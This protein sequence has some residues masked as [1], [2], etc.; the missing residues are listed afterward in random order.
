MAETRDLLIEIGTEELPP[1]ALRK[2]SE[3]LLQELSH[4]LQAAGLIY[5][6][7]KGYGAPRRLAV[8]VQA[9][10]VSQPEQVLERRGP[11]L[12][13][14]F[15]EEGKPTAAARGF[16]GSCGVPVEALESLKNEKGAW[17][18]YRQRQ[19]GAPTRELLPAILAQALQALPI[20]KPMRW[21]DLPGEFIRPVHWLVLLFGEEVIP[22]TLLGVQAG[23]ETQGHRFHHPEP[24]Y[25]TEPAAYATLLETEGKVLADFAVRREAIYTQV[26]AAAQQMGGKALIEEALLDEVTG[27]V[28]WPVAL[29][30]QFDG[31]FLKLP[32]EVLI[33]TMQDHQKYFPVQDEQGHLLPCFITVCNIESQRPEV[34]V[35]GNE[36][37]IRPRLTDAAFFYATD[38]KESLASRCE[39]LKK[40]TFQEKLGSVFERTERLAKLAW[41]IA[42]DIGGNGD[43]AKRAGLLSKC[44]LV[45]E[46]VTEFPELQGSMGRYYALHDHEPQEVAEALREQYLPR[47]AGDVLPRTATGQALSLADRLDT[48]VGLFG[49]GAPPSGDKDPYG[50]RRAAL[51]VL[52][53]IIE[54]GLALDLPSLLKRACET[55]ND[56]LTEKN[57]AVQVHA[58]LLERLRGYYLEAGF[59]PDEIEAVLAVR[60]D[61]PLDFDRRLKAV[62]SFRK[63]PE[64][65]SLSA[66]NKRIRNILRKSGE[67]LPAQ[68]ESD[69]LQ[70]PAEQ[71]LAT[72]MYSLEREMMPL[73]ERQDHRA[74][75]T[76]LAGLRGAVDQF[77]DEVMVMVEDPKLRANRLALLARL[78][79]LFLQVADISR[80]QA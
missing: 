39:R 3:S 63:L 58:Y 50:L 34:V 43:W 68:I 4:G 67:K 78:Q 64:A 77:F 9:L 16:A 52:R 21:S 24:L 73:L 45:T 5:G 61:Q 42:K 23:R 76:A 12:A 51:G 1:K 60:P 35:E 69:L 46:M 28:E 33:A 53:I 79:T 36:R 47:F 13:A 15:N 38:R 56:R 11:A 75:L 7:L 29:A 57:T 40:I 25:L 54:S 44:D 65:E 8:W 59:R 22:A 32:A 26:V 30:G 74:T 17:L 48:L 55:Y 31:D 27:L 72:Q 6:D 18:V 66:A 37:V 20:P 19:Q 70:D 10:T 62:A 49:I 71:T 80:L 14:A 41:H 2:L